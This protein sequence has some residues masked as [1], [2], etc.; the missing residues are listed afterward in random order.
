MNRGAVRAAG[1]LLGLLAAA[2]LLRLAATGD[3]SGPPLASLGEL[4]AWVDAC[5]PAA[6]GVALVRLLAEL[7]A[8][9]VLGLSLL[10]VA[11]HALRSAGGHRLADS[12]AVPGV[13]RAVRAGLGLGLVAASSVSGRDA[14]APAGGTATMA[15]AIEVGTATARSVAHPTGTATMTPAERRDG[16]ATMRPM[17]DA[18]AAAGTP[19]AGLVM[20]PATWTVV[21][22]ESLWSIAEDVLADAWGRPPSD[23][24]VEPF[25]QRLV[26]AN[27]G[28]L[29]DPDAPD[30]IHPGQVFEVPAVP[31]RP[32]A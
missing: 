16:T 1:W 27:R 18:S 19:T 11:S 5:S 4:G 15:P 32:A 7:S 29:V 23:H 2:T 3:L 8:W 30:L 14:D 22:G 9:Y 20:A 17:A 21:A 31:A 28:R 10:H 26:E 12:L 24:E 25:W 6:A 13:R